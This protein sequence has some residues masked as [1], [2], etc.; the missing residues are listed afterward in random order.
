MNF[1]TQVQEIEQAIN[2]GSELWPYSWMP[3]AEA[4][5]TYKELI[6][7]AIST[8]RHEV[9]MPIF[10]RDPGPTI[11]TH[12]FINVKMRAWHDYVHVAL[13]KP[14]TLKGELA[15]TMAMLQ[16]VF[17]PIAKIM[18]Y[19]ETFG[20]VQYWYDHRA[21]VPDQRNWVFTKTQDHLEIEGP[22]LEHILRS[23]QGRSSK[24]DR[25]QCVI[26]SANR[27]KR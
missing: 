13:Q 16:Y 24:H 7:E 22:S 14:F 5:S 9:P 3:I 12:P 8:L 26:S 10:S 23:N 6:A 15:V 18:L 20:Q 1:V 2:Y 21:Y 4:P 17:S 27:R 19:Y 11:Y 25:S